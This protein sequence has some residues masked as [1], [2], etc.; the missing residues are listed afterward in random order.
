MKLY[1]YEAKLILQKYGIT[2]P[3]GKIARSPDEASTVARELGIPVF[4]KSQI[5]VSGRGKAGGILPAANFNEALKIA[6]GLLDHEIK[7]IPVKTL[8]VEEKINIREQ[9][10]HLHSDRPSS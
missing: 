10:L 7:G 9:L 2:V 8:L 5:T 1:E 3:R 6:S 4:L